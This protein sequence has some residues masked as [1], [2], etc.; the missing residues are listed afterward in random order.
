LRILGLD[1]DCLHLFLHLDHL[2]WKKK[3]KKERKK[4]K[5]VRKDIEVKIKL[6]N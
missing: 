3:K 4:E 5:L 6:K 1:L 2:D